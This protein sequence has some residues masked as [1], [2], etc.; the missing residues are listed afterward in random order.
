MVDEKH[1]AEP[2]LT[3]MRLIIANMH[4]LVYST[5]QS[6]ASLHGRDTSS[7]GDGCEFSAWNAGECGI[8]GEFA[9]GVRV[10]ASGGVEFSECVVGSDEGAGEILRVG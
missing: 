7:C 5:P 2:I 1:I 4:I 8:W 9:S 3:V 6:V 10:A